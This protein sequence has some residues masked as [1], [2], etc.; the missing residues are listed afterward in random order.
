VLAAGCA[1]NGQL[2]IFTQPN[3]NALT[4]SG[5]NKFNTSVFKGATD[6]GENRPQF[7]GLYYLWGFDQ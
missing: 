6:G 3:T 1:S 4:A 2:L 5:R 7:C